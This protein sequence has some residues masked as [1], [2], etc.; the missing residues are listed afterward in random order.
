ME[1]L[2]EKFKLNTGLQRVLIFA[3]LI[4]VLYLLRSMINLILLTFIFTFFNYAPRKSYFALG[5]NS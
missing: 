2:W 5:E 4:F 3:L 1:E